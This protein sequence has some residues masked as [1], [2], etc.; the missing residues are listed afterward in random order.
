MFENQITNE[1]VT[2]LR[3]LSSKIDNVDRRLRQLEDSQQTSQEQ[4]RIARNIQSMATGMQLAADYETSK[5]ES[6]ILTAISPAH[7]DILRVLA[8]AGGR[9]LA[10]YQLKDLL[11]I[12]RTYVHTLLEHLE[13][14]RMVKRIPNFKKLS[15]NDQDTQS[16]VT[17]RHLF[18][19]NPSCKFPNELTSVV[20]ELTRTSSKS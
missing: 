4:L 13:R 10:V 8:D 14:T 5:L 12:S 11:S 9:A 6:E 18:T 3:E 1:I 7:L 17:P 19:I 20:P 2:L 15:F 16:E